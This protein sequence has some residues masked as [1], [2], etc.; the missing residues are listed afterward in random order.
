MACQTHLLATTQTT[1]SS[2]CHSTLIA[3]LQQ[4]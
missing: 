3:A 4:P 2:A 1:A